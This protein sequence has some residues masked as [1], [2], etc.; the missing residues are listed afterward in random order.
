MNQEYSHV[1]IN[2]QWTGWNKATN[3]T[4]P[5]EQDYWYAN[6][7]ID[8]E[9]GKLMELPALLKHPKYKDIWQEAA[10]N[11]YRRLFQG[12]KKNMDGKQKITGTNTCFWCKISQ[13]PK[14]KKVTYAR[15]VVDIQP[16]KEDPNCVQITT[17]GNFY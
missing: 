1:H 5:V 6:P 8:D 9:R 15:T 7:V 2:E 3:F 16:K 13:V 14:N 10:Y 17:G 12:N 4:P 11:E